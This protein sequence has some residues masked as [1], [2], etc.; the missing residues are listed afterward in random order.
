[1]STL[2]TVNVIE[3]TDGTPDS[4]RAFPDTPEGNKEAEECFTAIAKENGC[5]D[6]DMPAAIEDGN[7]TLGT[8]TIFLVH[9]S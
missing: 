8:Y 1:M 5:S 6:E 9:S 3:T 2:S 7:H 4:L